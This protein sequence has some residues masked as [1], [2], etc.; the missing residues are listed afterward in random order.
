[1]YITPLELHNQ[2]LG[3]LTTNNYRL[4]TGWG[5]L[6]WLYC[7][8]VLGDVAKYEEVDI[9]ECFN[10]LPRYTAPDHYQT[11]YDA[12]IVNVRNVLLIHP[13]QHRHDTRCKVLEGIIDDL[14]SETDVDFGQHSMAKIIDGDNVVFNFYG[15]LAMN[16]HDYHGG[17]VV[18]KVANHYSFNG[19][20]K[21]VPKFLTTY[22]EDDAAAL[23][24]LNTNLKESKLS[25]SEAIVR[26][27]EI[28]DD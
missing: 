20:I 2:W 12:R 14:R 18:D 21:G 23:V 11:A 4:F 25:R 6:K 7:K 15:L 28:L 3:E 9:S 19:Q 8:N 13:L 1:M 27:Q 5:L 10:Y 17:V 16:T 24:D 26:L 22:F